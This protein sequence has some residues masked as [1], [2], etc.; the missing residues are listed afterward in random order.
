LPCKRNVLDVTDIQA[1]DDAVGDC[2]IMGPPKAA[3]IE[4]FATWGP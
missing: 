2:E 3:G 4:H 1:L